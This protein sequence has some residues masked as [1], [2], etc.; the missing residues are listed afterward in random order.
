MAKNVYT[1]YSQTPEQ[2]DVTSNKIYVEAENSKEA[3]DKALEFCFEDEEIVGWSCEGVSGV[4]A[5][6]SPVDG[7]LQRENGA[8]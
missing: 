6:I 4:D 1:V 5:R 3:C 7:S 8:L 2:L